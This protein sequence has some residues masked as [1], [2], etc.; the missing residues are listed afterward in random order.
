MRTSS[1]LALLLTGTI[2]IASDAR[3]AV[4]DLCG[5]PSSEAGAGEAP[6]NGPKYYVDQNH[7][8][9][10][11]TNPGTEA[12]PW[13]TL[14][15]AAAAAQPG[16]TIL[17]K[18]GIYIDQNPRWDNP[19]K[20][21][22]A[23]SGTPGQ[24]ITF[25]SEPR[26]AAVI[27]GL[28]TQQPAWTIVFRSYIAID[29]FRIEGQLRVGE[30]SP[31]I[32]LQNN[33][34][35]KGSLQGTDTSL[36]W[37]IAVVNVDRVLVRNNYVHDMDPVIGNHGLN[38]AAIQLFGSTKYNVIEHNEADAGG[39][40]VHNAF[41][42]KAAPS[43]NLWRYN[44][45]RNAT[46]GFLGIATTDGSVDATDNVYIQNIILDSAHAFHL[47]HQA[48]RFVV[49]NNT[50]VGVKHFLHASYDSNKDARV[51]NNIAVSAT[52][53][54]S[55]AAYWLAGYSSQ[56][57][58]PSLL[59][60]ADHNCFSGFAR[61]GYREQSPTQVYT[62]LTVWQTTTGLDGSSIVADPQFL[63]A[64]AGD[65]HLASGSACATAGMDEQDHDG[66]G[67]TTEAIPAGAY[68]TGAEIIGRVSSGDALA[69]AA[70]SNLT[71]Q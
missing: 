58:F 56:Q 41:G 12:L 28:T 34:V 18:A 70:P 45:A 31:H 62:T 57:L 19:G 10:S 16:D 50:A 21:T 33:E 47:D 60:H 63:N 25:R 61:L 32:T 24:P 2:C 22:P 44:I 67:N 38:S 8:A 64:A 13:L 3:A 11:D 54:P 69:P 55:D 51:W 6:V 37:G 7:P 27:R 40:I 53:G 65:Y 1:L 49:Y 9:A 15:K 43:C 71:V 35:T 48:L 68:I 42:M 59:A 39:G 20:F 26:G 36:H 14:D 5:V 46:A 29:G 4:V 17:V 23:H 30:L 52:P 66:D